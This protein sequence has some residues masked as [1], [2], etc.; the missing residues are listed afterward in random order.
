MFWIMLPNSLPTELQLRK[1]STVTCGADKYRACSH[2]TKI[3]I[4]TIWAE[5]T[6]ANQEILAFLCLVRESRQ[7]C[8]TVCRYIVNPEKKNKI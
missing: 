3:I 4:Y 5:L 6:D 8:G 2:S 7:H 1:K